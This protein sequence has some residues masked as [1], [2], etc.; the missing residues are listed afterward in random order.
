[1]E[2][3]YRVHHTYPA[4]IDGIGRKGAFAEGVTVELEPG[5]DQAWTL[6]AFH[7]KGLKE[8]RL[9]SGSRQVFWRRNDD[10]A[11]EWEPVKN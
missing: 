8:Y 5:R 10:S 3:Y 1:M 2:S 11:S 9:S 7:D 4:T 6:Q